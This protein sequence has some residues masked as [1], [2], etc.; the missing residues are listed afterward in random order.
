MVLVLSAHA[1]LV[2]SPNLCWHQRR[3]L[4]FKKFWFLARKDLAETTT[5]RWHLR[6]YYIY[7]YSYPDKLCVCA[8]YTFESIKLSG[9]ILQ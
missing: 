5:E 6:L 8:Q 3:F 7:Y 4:K 2:A 9:G 1:L